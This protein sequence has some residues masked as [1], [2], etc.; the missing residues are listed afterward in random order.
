VRVGT[1]AE[2]LGAALHRHR[3]AIL[4]AWILHAFLIHYFLL[5][6][7]SW[8]GLTYRVPPAVEIA[9]H[10]VFRWDA[11]NQGAF[12]GYVP[13]V[14]LAHVPFLYVFK[15]AG[16]LI[17]FPLVV[18]PLCVLAVYALVREL[19]DDATSATFGAVA[20]AAMPFVNT[21]P[22]SGYV[23]FVVSA[24]LAFFA[25]ALLRVRSGKAGPLSF[26]R[27]GIATALL[28]LSR[29]QGL[30]LVVLFVPL[31]AGALFFRW[32]KRRPRLE[33][34]RELAWTLVATAGGALP[35]AAIQLVKLLRYGT[36]VYP[37]RFELL[38]VGL[39][40]GFSMR[41]LFASCG[42]ENDSLP[43]LARAFVGSW[44][45]PREWPMGGFFDSR[46]LGGG[47]VLCIGLLLAP[48]FVR[49]ATRKELCFAAACVIATVLARDFWLP[50]YAYTLVVLI[51]LV[52]GRGMSKLIASG[53]GPLF[54]GSCAA[55]LVHFA[56]PEIDLL[57]LRGPRLNVTQ[58][59]YFRPGDA[60]EPMPDLHAKLVIIERTTNGFV[61]P[62]YG[63]RLTNEIVQTIPAAAIGE[64]C[65]TL[66]ESVT[67][68]PDTLFI[69]DLNHTAD[70]NRE[71]VVRTRAGL[72][73]AYRL[74]Q[75]SFQPPFVA[76]QHR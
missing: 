1:S 52:V 40:A 61:L 62:L 17:G 30:Y 10:G 29:T 73:R 41:E 71:C 43:E 53:G 45:W 6:F 58:S 38:G 28:T 33:R 20:Y 14:E 8:D 18:F 2:R 37:L 27:L 70:C 31:L 63:G 75:G 21:Q 68:G 4:A 55:L 22:Y 44:I 25:Y 65:A 19:T 39:S 64:R 59:A 16:T 5:G 54:W 51:A 72:C 34:G 9:Q 11:F 74:E 49:M 50:R 48:A 36:P 13:F 47:F 76:R 57:V 60:I 67:Q 15:L 24:L 26:V 69:D 3:L 56:R 7:E 23:D 42:L 66:S 35:A 46:N 32:E 12:L